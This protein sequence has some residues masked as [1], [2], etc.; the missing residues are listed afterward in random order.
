[1]LIK[2]TKMKNLYK[3]IGLLATL[4]L[5]ACNQNIPS[6]DTANT[7]NCTGQKLVQTNE[8][9]VQLST[10][11]EITELQTAWSELSPSISWVGPKQDRIVKVTV[12]TNRPADAVIK[13]LG[14]IPQVAQVQYNAT[15]KKLPAPQPTTAP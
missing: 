14:N 12:E 13:Q 9:I 7:D 6:C 10:D 1:M 15:V 4:L 3:Y 8:Y 5:V 2:A 11:I